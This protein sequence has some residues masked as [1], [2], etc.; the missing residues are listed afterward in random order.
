LKIA[1]DTVMAKLESERVKYPRPIEL[2]EG[3]KHC[4]LVTAMEDGRLD[5]L[6]HYRMKNKVFLINLLFEYT[7]PHV[8]AIQDL[9]S[10]YSDD[11]T[12]NEDGYDEIQTSLNDCE[13]GLLNE[14]LYENLH[15]SFIFSFHTSKFLIFM[16][17]ILVH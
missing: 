16:Q 8:R 1:N 12:G 4:A 5:F 14:F 11:V 13:W 7:D 3:V 2:A 15:L 17:L 6:K 9:L 10:I